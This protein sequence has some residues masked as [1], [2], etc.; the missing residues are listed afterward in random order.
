MKSSLSNHS[1]LRFIQGLGFQLL[2]ALLIF[3]FGLES[4]SWARKPGT[5][6]RV[7]SLPR[8]KQVWVP[9]GRFTMGSPARE[10][11][12][13]EDEAQHR[14]TL[15]RGFWMLRTEVTQQ[16]FRRLMGYNPSM[17]RRKCGRKC[18]VEQ[19]NWYQALRFANRLSR[20]HRLPLCYVCRRRRYGWRCWLRRRY[21]KQGRKHYYRCRGWRLP[22][23]AEWEYAARAGSQRARY[24]SLRRSAWYRKNSRFRVHPVARKKPNRWGLYDMLGNVHEWVWDLYEEYPTSAVVDPVGPRRG[25]DRI[26]RGGAWNVVARFVRAAYRGGNRPY[27]RYPYVGFRLVRTGR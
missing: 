19:V 18:P 27:S 25:R 24:S 10:K 3:S 22:T 13:K 5:V 17:S 2:F 26:F 8:G 4:E 16:Q 12:R 9:P 7:R 11:G 20:K 6:R 15:R 14:V 1:L 23:E 21:R